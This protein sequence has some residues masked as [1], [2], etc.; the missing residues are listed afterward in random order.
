[1]CNLSAAQVTLQLKNQGNEAFK[2]EVYGQSIIVER[3]INADGGGHWKIKS[4]QGK[5]VSTKREELNAICDHAN[6]QVC[7]PKALSQTQ[8]ACWISD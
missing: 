8:S 3:R 5:T 2:P 7:C 1:M 4:A 6:I